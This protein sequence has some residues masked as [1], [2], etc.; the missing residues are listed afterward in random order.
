MK[1]ALSLLLAELVL[2]G[3]CIA[4]PQSAP[5]TEKLPPPFAVTISAAQDVVKAGSVVRVKTVLTN[6]SD[7]RIRVVTRA[8][9][10]GPIDYRI[11][12]RNAQGNPVQPAKPDISKDK[13]G[14]TIRRIYIGS[15]SATTVDLKPGQT[16]TD[17]FPVAKRFDLTQPGKY[18]I[19]ASR[20]DYETKTWV[21]SNTITLT[22][23][24]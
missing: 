17:E 24:P 2:A 14:R 20:Y 21:K 9:G 23:E 15:S 11:D 4:R 10:G 18:T 19:Q 13:N 1:M 22:V 5:P 8:G 16:L 7:H 3:V 6:T 12:V